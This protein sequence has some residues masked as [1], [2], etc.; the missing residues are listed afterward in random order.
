M[1]EG[2]IK[3][4]DILKELQRKLKEFDDATE[5]WD[6]L[7]IS[8][9]LMKLGKKY[10]GLELPLEFKAEIIAFDLHED[11]NSNWDLYYGPMFEVTNEAGTIDQ[12]PALESITEEVIDYWM[13]R[14]KQSKHYNLIIRYA[15][16]VWEFSRAVTKKQSHIDYPHLV[17]D[18]TIVCAEN[19]FFTSD[20]RF[21]RSLKRALS[22]AIQINDSNRISKLTDVII[23]FEEKVAEDGKPGLWGFSFDWLL[24]SKQVD[25]TKDQRDKIIKDLEERLD[26]VSTIGDRF[27]PLA[28]EAA[29]ERLAKY[30][31]R[32]N[33]KDDIYRI[34]QKFSSA[35]IHAS[36]ESS[37]MQSSHWLQMVYTLFKEFGFKEEAEKI[38][39]RIHQ[40]S[41]KVHENLKEFSQQFELPTDKINKYIES[42]VADSLD[43]AFR[44]IT[45]KFL[46]D[47]DRVKQQIY[48]LYK[49]YPLSFLISKQLIDHKGRVLATIGS[50]EE[51]EGGNVIQQMAQNLQVQ[52]V[53][54]REVIKKTIQK[55]LLD[56]DKIL[57]YLLQSPSFEQSKIEILRLGLRN[58]LNNDNVSAIH[59]LIPQIEDSFRKLLEICGGTILKQSRSGDG[60]FYKTLEEI[61]RDERLNQVFGKG[62]TL[63]FRVVLTDRRGWNVRNNVAHGLT[64]QDGFNVQITDRLFHIL[65]CLAAVRMENSNPQEK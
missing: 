5:P 7:V 45:I 34:L 44:R 23:R 11:S 4:V 31:R 28:V 50:L 30:Y 54:L 2:V 41:P 57:G 16:L 10:D 24:D 33:R 19:D 17:I 46:E 8:D 58:Y 49:E 32:E 51:D 63:Y 37:P 22:I 62:L 9:Q 15:D 59:L 40:L 47:G 61:L 29:T 43:E 21:K 20:V 56:E 60:F 48:D 52:A 42:I 6:K 39:A 38:L 36:E 27:N 14:A 35:F 53:F 65:L 64:P 26:R 3:L 55:Y 25:L 18:N 1:Q 13:K 12:Y